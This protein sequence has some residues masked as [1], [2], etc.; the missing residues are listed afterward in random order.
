MAMIVCPLE[1]RLRFYYRFIYPRCTIIRKISSYPAAR[2]KRKN[3][4][5]RRCLVA[6]DLSMLKEQKEYVYFDVFI[7]ATSRNSFLS[8]APTIRYLQAISIVHK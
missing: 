2:G 3:W 8:I 4:A 6:D 7:I 1:W 5:I